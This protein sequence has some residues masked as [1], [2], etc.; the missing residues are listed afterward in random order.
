MI[1]AFD[2]KTKVKDT[3]LLTANSSGVRD[4]QVHLL[5]EHEFDDL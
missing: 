4:A 5:S 3:V 2:L 1:E